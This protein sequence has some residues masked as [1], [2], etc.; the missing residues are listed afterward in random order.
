MRIAVCFSGQTRALEYTYLNLK[1]YLI[2]SLGCD[3]FIYAAKDKFS[4]GLEDCLEELNPVKMVLEE[5]R[6][7]NEEGLTCHPLQR[8]LQ[9]YIQMLNSWKQADLLRLRFQK[10]HGFEYDFVIRTRLDVRFF[11][12][13]SLDLVKGCD[14]AKYVYVPDFHSYSCV[15]GY[16]CN[17]RFAIG[18]SENISTYSKMFDFINLYSAQG[19]IIHAESTLYYHLKNQGVEYRL[20]PVRFTR[21]RPSGIELDSHI[22]Q[23]AVHWKNIELPYCDYDK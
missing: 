12:K 14:V 21:V 18:S 4:V 13:I 1:E 3:V 10:E 23:S 17:D 11:E 15:Q 20:I 19:H 8:S 16:G 9:Q 5:D 6:P 22:G 7:I 2:D